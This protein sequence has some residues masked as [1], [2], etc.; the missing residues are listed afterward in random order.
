[1]LQFYFFIGT[2]IVFIA[3]I[4]GLISG[5]CFRPPETH[6]IEEIY[7]FVGVVTLAIIL[8]AGWPFYSFI[9]RGLTEKEINEL[10]ENR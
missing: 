5:L 10:I 6:T 8:L 4:I 1:M 2:I 7:K 3:L 9:K